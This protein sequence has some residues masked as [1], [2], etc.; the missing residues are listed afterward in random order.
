MSDDSSTLSNDLESR[1]NRGRALRTETA[2]TAAGS[3][4]NRYRLPR[5][6]T[7]RRLSNSFRS[8]PL[9]SESTNG[10]LFSFILLN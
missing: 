1:D 4:S 10:N 2:N 6:E 8:D 5:L 7:L 3:R 9:S